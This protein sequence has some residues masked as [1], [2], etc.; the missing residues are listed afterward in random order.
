MARD[1][2]KG[3]TFTPEQAIKMIASYLDPRF[4]PYFRSGEVKLIPGGPMVSTEDRQELVALRAAILNEN[5]DGRTVERALQ[6]YYP[7]SQH[8]RNVGRVFEGLTSEG[9]MGQKAPKDPLARDPSDPGFGRGTEEPEEPEEDLTVE[10]IARRE[11]ERQRLEESTVDVDE[12]RALLGQDDE[13]TDAGGDGRDSVSGDISDVADEPADSNIPENWREAAREMYPQYYAIVRNIPEIAQLLE[14]AINQSYTPEKFQ[15]ELEQTNWFQQTSGSAREWEINSQRDP[16]SAQSQIDQKIVTIRDLALSS[17]GVRL[18]DE[19]LS[20]LAEDSLRFGWSNRFLQN[21]IGDVAT[22]STTGIS[23]LREGYI[24]QQLRKTANDYGIAVS[25]ATFNQWVNKVAVGK[26]STASWEDYAKVQAK[27]L[28]PSISERIDAGETFQQIVDPYRESAAALLEID[29]GTI[30]FKQ[31]D[32][33]KAVTFQ[34][35]KGE[36]RPMSFTEWND[37]VRQN[38]SFGYE[39]TEQAQRRAYQVA[40]SLAN[41]FGKV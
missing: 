9:K 8:R 31:P 7:L 30:D 27:N 36:Q 35:E 12:R 20:E 16:A 14:D 19:R 2:Q 38:R 5:L 23:Q 21:A 41:L 25:D 33:I 1:V 10:E 24:G 39:Y 29:G 28:F 34:D 32:W 13:S 6:K 3:E 17:F 11:L 18:S 15:A 22:T 4:R 40:N 37:Y 26:E